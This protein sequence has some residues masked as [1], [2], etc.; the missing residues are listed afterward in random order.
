[1]I[2]GIIISLMCIVLVRK[3]YLKHMTIVVE[4]EPTGDGKNVKGISIEL[5]KDGENGL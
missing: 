4:E 2:I 5:E 3:S 1:M